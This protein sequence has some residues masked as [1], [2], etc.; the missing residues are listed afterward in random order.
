MPDYT[1]SSLPK[2]SGLIITSG[3]Y[4]TQL[5]PQRGKKEATKVILKR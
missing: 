3:S 4:I 5:Q 2:P 1:V